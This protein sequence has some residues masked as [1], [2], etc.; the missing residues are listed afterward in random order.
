MAEDEE[1][2]PI[3]IS[4]TPTA[5]S[6]ASEPVVPSVASVAASALVDAG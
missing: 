1:N 6:V 5:T 3:E 2:I 4:I